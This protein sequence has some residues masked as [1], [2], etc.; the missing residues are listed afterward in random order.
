MTDLEQARIAVVEATR[1][2]R[3]ASEMLKLK[4][5]ARQNAEQAEERV[6]YQMVQALSEMLLAIEKLEQLEATTPGENR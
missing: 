5:V 6:R 1:A 2:W 4:A 3:D